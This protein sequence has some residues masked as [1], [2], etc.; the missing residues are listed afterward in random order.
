MAIDTITTLQDVLDYTNSN[1]RASS[2]QLCSF[3]DVEEETIFNTTKCLG[4]D[5]YKYLKTDLFLPTIAPVIFEDSTLYIIGDYVSYENSVYECV[6]DTNGL[7]SPSNSNNF[8]KIPKFIT[9]ASN[10][11]WERYLAKII[12]WTVLVR[13]I[14]NIATP[15]TE[16]G[17]VR[18]KGDN[19]A[20][21]SI[22]E[23]DI[24]KTNFIDARNELTKNMELFLSRNKENYPQTEYYKNNCG[25]NNCNSNYKPKGY[26]G[27]LGIQL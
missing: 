17:L 25:S 27:R 19:F 4:W 10:E 23:M 7:Q 8:K 2:V 20:P 6:A 9:A 22:Q 26:Y 14:D 24:K 5:Y 18:T 3:I 11:I 15:I 1:I 16:Q 21:A 12:S 13:A